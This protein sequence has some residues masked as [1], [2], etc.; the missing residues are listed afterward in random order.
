MNTYNVKFQNANKVAVK[1]FKATNAGDAFAR[2]LHEFPK[3]KLVEAF[4][5][6][7]YAGGYGITSYEPPSTASPNGETTQT[8]EQLLFPFESCIK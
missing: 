7:G 3:A 5:E 2:C 1:S 4:R 6:G 8:A